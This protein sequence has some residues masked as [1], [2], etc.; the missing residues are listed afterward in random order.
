MQSIAKQHITNKLVAVAGVG[1]LA[2]VSSLILLACKSRQLVG[3][4]EEAHGGDK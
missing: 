3:V 4:G 2:V 1:I